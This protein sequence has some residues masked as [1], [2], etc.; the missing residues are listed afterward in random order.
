VTAHGAAQRLRL[1]D[2]RALGFAVYG[3]PSGMPLLLLHGTPGAHSQIAIG[4]AAGAERGL[5]IVAPDRWGYGHTDMPR[6]PTL[7]RF[8]ADMGALMDH[9]GHARFALGGISGG[10]PY[11]CSVAAHLAARVTAL[12]L[13]SPMGPVAD[14]SVQHSL[15]P[16]HRFVFTV[17]PHRP[18]AV[19]AIFRAFR[20]SLERSPRLAAQLATLR[21][22]A[23]DK[24]LIAQPGIAKWLLGSFRDGLRPGTAGPLQDLRT[25]ARAWDVDLAAIRAPA[26]LW[27]GTADTAVPPKAARLLARSIAGCVVTELASEGHLWVAA[28]YKDVLDWIIAASGQARVATAGVPPLFRTDEK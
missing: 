17:L 2:G 28:H 10:G 20:A 14:P 18:L 9:L 12:A 27:I 6:D 16:F 8:A 21:A 15:T 1:A 4:H 26:R 25:F 23:R 5:A 19:A 13:I 11:A 22:G 3:D 7:A 24:A